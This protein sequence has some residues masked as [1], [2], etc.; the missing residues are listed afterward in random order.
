MWLDYTF[1]F[2]LVNYQATTSN[3]LLKLFYLFEKHYSTLGEEVIGI[4][5][6]N[7]DVGD[8]NSCDVT[9]SASC[10]ATGDDFGL[11]KLFNFPCKDKYVSF[12]FTK[13]FYDEKEIFKTTAL[14]IFKC[15]F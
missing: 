2:S 5:P 6:K 14:D 12:V 4:W 13:I 11:V 15:L 9:G 3:Y 10:V 1:T 8:V 7:S